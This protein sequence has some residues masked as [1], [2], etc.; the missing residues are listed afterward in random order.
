MFKKLMIAASALAIC[1]SLSSADCE[2]KT[3]NMKSPVNV[4]AAQ[5]RNFIGD[6]KTKKYHLP[7]CKRCPSEMRA[8]VLDSPMSA[9]RAGFK[10]CKR[11]HPP[12]IKN[13]KK[14][15]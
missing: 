15:R 6:T 5:Q 13:L 10:P 1:L 3:K 14:G 9:K 2:A 7:N 11:C 4:P 12:A 8:V